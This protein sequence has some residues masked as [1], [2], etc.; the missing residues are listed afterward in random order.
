MFKDFLYTKLIEIMQLFLPLENVT[1]PSS[2]WS[3]AAGYLWDDFKFAFT[4]A[5]VLKWSAWVSLSTCGY[6]MV[7][8]PTTSRVLDP[9]VD[10]N[11]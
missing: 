1:S 11:F 5:Y 8:I 7:I 4:N 10:F 6:T 3:N 9:S 2:S